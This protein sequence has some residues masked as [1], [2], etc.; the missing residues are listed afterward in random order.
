MIFNSE[1]NLGHILTLTAILIAF[2]GHRI[3]RSWDNKIK[4]AHVKVI[5]R[6]NLKQ[7]KNDF[8]RIRKERNN[9][10]PDIKFDPTSF[11]E[12]SGYYF[13]FS[14]LLLPNVEQL[15]LS[16]YPNTIE[17]FIHYKINMET[18]KA[19]QERIIAQGNATKLAS[20]TKNTVDNLLEKL[21]HSITEFM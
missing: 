19:R 11:S 18:I 21:D 4:K 1:V 5:M 7:L 9:D 12:I 17:F 3:W 8:N 2:F 14:E 20:L 15:K 13:L 10:S 16:E 6:E